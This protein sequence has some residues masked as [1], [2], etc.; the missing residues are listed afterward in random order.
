MVLRSGVPFYIR[1]KK[2]KLKC[3][4]DFVPILSVTLYLKKNK[5]NNINS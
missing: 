2:K 4:N 1:A 3:L 5:K